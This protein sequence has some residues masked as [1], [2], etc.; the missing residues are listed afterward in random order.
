MTDQEIYDE[1]DKVW[2]TKVKWFSSIDEFQKVVQRC[3]GPTEEYTLESGEI[4]TGYLIS[5]WHS[6]WRSFQHGWI[7]AYRHLNAASTI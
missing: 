5:Y 4:I 6:D 1:C 3:H 7:S 2:L